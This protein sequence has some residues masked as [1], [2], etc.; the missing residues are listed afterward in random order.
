MN[1]LDMPDVSGETGHVIVHYLYTEKYDG[2]ESSFGSDALRRSFEVYA[3]ATKYQI[4]DL[5]EKAQEAIEA[6][7]DDLNA[8][9]ALAALKHA[10]PLPDP[11]DVWL[12]EYT[13]TLVNAAY[14]DVSSFLAS[15]IMAPENAES[16]MSITEMIL[17]A[18]IRSA[19]ERELSL[20][21][22]EKANQDVFN[23]EL[24]EVN[25]LEAKKESR[26]GKL[27]KKD[28]ARLSELIERLEV[29][30]QTVNG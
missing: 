25:Q 24:A 11:R 22:V 20:A 14:A 18:V 7:T 27:L 13:K 15:D 4:P 6:N 17:R 30:S 1:A 2:V 5:R 23:A 3:A 19:K 21:E 8:A 28:Q 10:C 16:T 29:S 26:G 12:H 9:E